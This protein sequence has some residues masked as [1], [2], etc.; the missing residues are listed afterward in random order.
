MTGGLY[1]S[2]ESSSELVGVFENLPTNIIVD[3]DVMEI[4]VLFAAI[5]AL[6]AFA[7]IA[8]SMLWHPLP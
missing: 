2:A 7:A 5:G 6:L 3:H 1:Y 4:S 8:L